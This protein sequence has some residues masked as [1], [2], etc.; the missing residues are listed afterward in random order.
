MF[1][2]SDF[3]TLPSRFPP[4]Y[5]NRKSFRNWRKSGVKI[6]VISPS[7]ESVKNSSEDEKAKKANFLQELFSDFSENTS[8]HGVKFIGQKS[9]HWTER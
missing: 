5:D 8:I 4:R 2:E 1:Y 6:N 9:F 7:G 3:R